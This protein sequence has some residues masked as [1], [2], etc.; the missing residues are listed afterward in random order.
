MNRRDFIK[1]LTA[2]VGAAAVPPAF[3]KALP[4]VIPG[5][6]YIA[7]HEETPS[8]YSGEVSYKEYA[9]VQ[10]PRIQY[11]EWSNSNLIEFP[12]SDHNARLSKVSISTDTGV[13]IWECPL[14]HKLYVSPG[15]TP[16]FAVG[17]LQITE[18]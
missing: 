13:V 14:S 5:N 3:A 7:L 17:A 9:R 11:G 16:M 10:V 8:S 4:E 2:L 1:S 6:W 12:E 18:D 15:T